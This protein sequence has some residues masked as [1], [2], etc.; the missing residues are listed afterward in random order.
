[1]AAG[2]RWLERFPIISVDGVGPVL[3]GCRRRRG[4]IGRQ[5]SMEKRAADGLRH[6]RGI[7]PERPTA[8]AARQ[9]R[10]P[11][12]WSVATAVVVLGP[13]SFAQAQSQSVELEQLKATL[14]QMQKTLAEQAQKIEALEKQQ[15]TASDVQAAAPPSAVEAV[16]EPFIVDKQAPTPKQRLA[17]RQ[18]NAPLTPAL[19]GFW[20]IPG[21]QMQ[22][23][24]GGD[25]IGVFLV[26]SKLMGATTWFVTSSIPVSGQPYANSLAQ[27][28]GTANQSDLNFEFRTPTPLG[29]LRVVYFN[30]F[31][32]PSSSA[33]T[34]HLKDFYIQAAN[35]LVGFAET[36]FADLDAQPSTLDYE[37]PNSEVSYR[38]MEVRYS[39]RIKRWAG[40]DL[41]M[42]FALENPSSQIPPSAGTPRSTAPDGVIALRLEGN[43]GHLQLATVLRAIGNQNPD[44]SQTQTVFGWGLNLTGNLNLFQADFLMLEVTGGQGM[45]A[46]VNDTSGLGLDAALNAGGQLTALGLLGGYLAYTHQWAPA[47]SST[48]S[49][50]YLVM[51]TAP[52]AVSLGPSA[53][54]RSQYVSLNLV[55]HPWKGLLV[56]AEGLWGYNRTTS[57]ASGQAWRGQLNLQYT[58]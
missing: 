15:G 49:Y 32:Q 24:V 36:A 42:R 26:T 33:F 58:F 21:T 25:S 47:W 8:G 31:A 44:N 14:E 17:P 29:Q 20:R 39:L 10:P 30:D 7:A 2:S 16:P 4:N 40:G 5:V 27:V 19:P 45:A 1:V 38:H 43:P 9:R 23:R 53:F 18:D 3:D 56:G 54:Q 52:Y 57:G 13:F 22:L 48:A 50:G 41:L 55:V 6:W 11:V 37:G 34:Y 51:D 35:L 28:T 46:Y 12:A